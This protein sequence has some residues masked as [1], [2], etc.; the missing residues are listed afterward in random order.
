M[1]PTPLINTRSYD[2]A[3]LVANGAGCALWV[4]AYGA[5]VLRI[6]RRRFVEIPAFV[7]AADLGWEL[8]WSV[9]FHPDT[10]RL[11]SLSYQGAF[12]LDLYIFSRILQYGDKQLTSD[13]IRPHFKLVCV[14]SFVFWALACTFYAREGYDTAIGANSGYVINVVLSAGSLLLMAR[15]PDV[16]LFSVVYAWCRALGTGL[17]TVSLFL[18][19]PH[20]R[21]VQLLGVTCG[22]IDAL[23]LV[24]LHKRLARR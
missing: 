9:L 4:V 24:V 1:D 21:F 14:A 22:L 5:L 10:G 2:V 11:Y 17:I 16:T 12:A 19:Y 23:Y 8:V 7:G 6:H 15:T 18:I 3:A 20:G 13:V